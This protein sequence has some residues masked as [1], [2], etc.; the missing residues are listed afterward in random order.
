[1]D[2]GTFMSVIMTQLPAI[3]GDR[4]DF[5]KSAPAIYF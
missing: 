1:M 3:A 5:A 4:L 2:L